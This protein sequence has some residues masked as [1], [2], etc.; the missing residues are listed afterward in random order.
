MIIKTNNDSIISYLED[1]SGLTGAHAD[2]VFLPEKY[3]EVSDFLK[4]A[5][6]K[7]IPI[8]I[9][10]GRTG[11]VGGCLPFSGEV[12]SFDRLNKILD[13]KKD[14]ITVQAG[15]F[16]LAIEKEAQLIG[17]FYPPDPTEKSATIGG[18]ISTNAKGARSF[19]YRDTRKYVNKIKVVLTNGDLFEIERGR[20]TADKKYFAGNSF[21][22]RIPDYVMPEIKNSSGYFSRDNMD[23]IDLFIG[24]EGTLGAIVEA[25]LK[26]LPNIGR[27][28]GCFAFFDK[29]FDALNFVFEAK[30]TDLISMEYFDNNA[31]DLLRE[32]VPNIQGKSQACVYFE[33]EI[34]PEKEYIYLD[35]WAKMLEKC[36]ADLES[37]WICDNPKKEE[38]F[39]N[40]R[41]KLPELVNEKVK[42]YGFPKL[43]TDIAV[44]EKHF[45]EM[46]KIYEDS[47][48]NLDIDHLIFG[49]MGDNHLHVNMLPKTENE[50]VKVRELYLSFVKKAVAFGG[51]VSA[52]H[53]IGKLK[54]RF[55]EE[56]YGKCGIQEMIRV[57]KFFDPNC[58]LGPDNIFP[59]EK[60]Q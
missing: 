40:I 56:M 50:A 13:V 7:K 9:S 44:P 11:V 25:E 5:N 33:K 26:I 46:F 31:L 34:T 37:A 3:G 2:K 14:A 27:I 45:R 15:A 57:K 10:G 12:L 1:A 43:G 36:N 47:L 20:Y 55:L 23:L 39:K 6:S 51:A 19:K 24:S 54:H 29:T 4:E 42:K 38:E 30:K 22:F 53:G 8:T 48:A 18:N 41:H 21:D 49:H 17:C 52:E 60:L 16:L 32:T 28:C 58:I 35:N 59:K